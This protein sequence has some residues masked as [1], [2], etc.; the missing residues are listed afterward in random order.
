M[1]CDAEDYGFQMLKDDE[2]VNPTLLKMKRMTTRTTTTT[3]EARV[4]QMLARFLSYKVVRTINRVLSY[5]TTAAQEN[6]RPCS[7]KAKVY[8][9]TEKKWL[10]STIKCPIAYTARNEFDIIQ[11]I[12]YKNGIRS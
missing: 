2:I 9:G 11:T 4:H 1:A 8:N 7:E 3:K 12:T 10:F 5:S 6:Q